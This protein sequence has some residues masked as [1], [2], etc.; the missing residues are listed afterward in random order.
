MKALI[1]RAAIAVSVIALVS[2][3]Q[4][5]TE[6]ST[7]DDYPNKPISI[8]VGFAPGGS[9]DT[10]MRK[11]NEVIRPMLNN[12]AIVVENRPG[13]AGSV[14]LDY[15]TRQAP[16]GYAL[17]PLLIGSVI[18]QHI[19]KV[20]Y[21]TNN[22]TPIVMFGTMP[23][24]IVVRQDS[25]WKTIQE[26][27][28]Y[29]KSNPGK[30]RYSTA[31]VGTA[32][33]FGME[34]IGKEQD[35]Q[36]IHVPYK[37]GQP[38]VTALLAGEVEA[39]AQTGEWKP[40]V[41]SGELR[42]LATFTEKRLPEYPDVPTLQEVGIDITAPSMMGMVGPKGMDPAIVQRLSDIYMKAIKDPGF[43]QT[44]NGLSMLPVFYSA[45]EFKKYLE[46]VNIYYADAA[47]KLEGVFE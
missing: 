8:I 39:T 2:A 46:E 10:L 25:P 18:N 4:Q 22:L 16:D 9:S 31:G 24:A 30:V 3:A 7:V 44:L 23:Q 28:E 40:F 27:L 14:G 17:G 15:L 34:K 47:K 20:D 32:Q 37:G 36:W 42:I 12:Q 13:A 35:I 33:H 6:A 1:R 21:D 19:R 5:N 26:F 38:A 43:Q 29:A 45:G 41:E 11:L